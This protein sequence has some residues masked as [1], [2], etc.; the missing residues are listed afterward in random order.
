M[1]K[2]LS[3][4]ALSTA[5]AVPGVANAT[6]GKKLCPET[7]ENPHGQCPTTPTPQPQPVNQNVHQN[8]HQ[9]VH[10]N[11]GVNQST[12]VGVK[13]DT[14]VGVGVGVKTG[15]NTQ[16]TTV[17]TGDT[18]VGVKTGDTNVGVRTGDT[19]VGV[20]TGDTTVNTGDTVVKTGDTTVNTG[21]TTIVDKSKTEQNVVD[22]STNDSNAISGSQSQASGN[23]VNFNSVYKA[24]AN[25]AAPDAAAVIGDGTCK[26]GVSI[27]LGVGTL[28][29]NVGGS[30]AFNTGWN[31]K[32][33]DHE[34]KRLEK[35]A[36]AD[37][38]FALRNSGDPINQALAH[39]QARQNSAAYDGASS[40]LEGRI[41]EMSQN[42][43]PVEVKEGQW[44]KLGGFNVVIRKQPVVTVTPPAPAPAVDC[45]AII[46]QYIAAS[47]ATTTPARKPAAK[48]AAPKPAVDT[49][50][51]Q[52]EAALKAHGLKP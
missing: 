1:K 28:D 26:T 11:V 4:L 51:P 36:D 52:V 24:A 42:G 40:A 2:L 38:E 31:E 37:R 25:R 29:T 12:N 18:H 33:A 45:K 48:P 30:V 20:K 3:I 19:H 43:Q 17:K 15:D 50:G 35:A 27:S 23:N 7:P 49:C 16:T 34:L 21:D 47:K 5:L 14:T 22:N 9:N 46:E 39:E 32:C 41:N 8:N 44:H 13:Q 6:G 10:Q